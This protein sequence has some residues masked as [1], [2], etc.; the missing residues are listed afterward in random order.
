MKERKIEGQCICGKII[1]Y[2][3][4][5]PQDSWWTKK[6]KIASDTSREEYNDAELHMI[7]NCIAQHDK[8][9]SELQK[10][11]DETIDTANYAIE[12]LKKEILELKEQLKET[13]LVIHLKEKQKW[14]DLLNW[15]NDNNNWSWAEKDKAWINKDILK[16]I[17]KSLMEK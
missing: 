9:M 15:V 1:E 11:L 5:Q 7:E 2:V 17:V 6:W 16:E 13:P 10:Y 3:K 14:Q 8:E 12:S 4:E